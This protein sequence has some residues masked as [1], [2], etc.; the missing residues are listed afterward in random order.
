MTIG[1]AEA[2]DLPQQGLEQ[3]TVAEVHR[4]L[5]RHDMRAAAK[6]LMESDVNGADL[7]AMTQTDLQHGLGMSPILARKVA[8]C[9]RGVL[10]S[11]A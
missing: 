5:L 7:L 9:F 8:H 1:G 3:W 10:P 4:F 2:T 6:V 11:A